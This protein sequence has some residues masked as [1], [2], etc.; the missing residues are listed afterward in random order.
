[1]VTTNGQ[2]LSIGAA[3]T[4]DIYILKCKFIQEDL[5]HTTCIWSSFLVYLFSQRSF[6][7][8][9]CFILR[10]WSHVLMHSK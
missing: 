3:E 6:D 2:S 4:L 7:P 8:E 1:M 10:L 5:L 9:I